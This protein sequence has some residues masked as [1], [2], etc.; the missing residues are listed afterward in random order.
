MMFQGRPQQQRGGPMGG[1]PGGH[2]MGAPVSKARDFRG[3]MRKLIEYLG[4][5]RAQIIIVLFSQSLRRRPT[6][7]DRR[8]SAMRPP[9]FSK[10]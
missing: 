7:R 8:S 3:T 1:G 10:A 9:N 4:A 6:S 2:M 5:Y